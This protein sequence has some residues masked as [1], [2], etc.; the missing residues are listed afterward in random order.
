MNKSLKIAKVDR[1]CVACG[2]C[3]KVCSRGAITI[4]NGVIAI[5]DSKLCVGC[6]LCAK[7]CP[8]ALIDVVSRGNDDEK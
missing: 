1:N 6:G 5:V 3:V 7:T 8:G 2:S 4:K